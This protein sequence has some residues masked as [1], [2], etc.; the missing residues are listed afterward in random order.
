MSEEDRLD[1][2]LSRVLFNPWVPGVIASARN[3]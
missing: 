2:V 1:Q 3:G